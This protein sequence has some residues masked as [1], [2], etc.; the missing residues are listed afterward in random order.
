MQYVRLALV[1][2]KLFLIA[3]WNGSKATNEGQTAKLLFCFFNLMY[4]VHSFIY[5]VLFS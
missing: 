3:P 4:N 1:L 2:M 5:L